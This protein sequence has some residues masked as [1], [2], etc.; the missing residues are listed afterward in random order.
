[1]SLQ[2][3][4]DGVFIVGGGPAGL[5]A[6]IAARLSGLQATVA[7][8]LQPPIDKACGEGLMPDAVAALHALRVR[9]SAR[10]AVPFRGIRF[11]DGRSGLSAEAPFPQGA[12][13][14]VRRTTLHAKLA[15]RAAELGAVLRWGARV[16]LLG[17]GKLL[18]D[19]AEVRCRWLIGAD[20]LQSRV[21]SWSG[22]QPKAFP[23]NANLPIGGRGANSRFG[24]RQHFRAVPW[25]DLVE[26]YWGASCQ[27]AVTPTAPDEVG[28]AMVT[29]NPG[30]RIQGALAE[31]PVLAAHLASAQPATRER[32][33]P[34]VLRRLPALSRGPVALIGDASGSVDPVTGEGLGLA[35]RQ[36]LSLAESLRS[37]DLRS[38]EHAH[39]RIGHVPHR[40]SRL[41]LCM[42]RSPWLRTRALQAMAAEPQLFARLLN[43]QI[44]GPESSPLT[45]LDALRL[46]WHMA[47][48]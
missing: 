3:G 47:K 21:R 19:G 6:A 9:F 46:G 40:M 33:A 2:A 10:Q 26:V 42:D 13:L 8:S 29:R 15:E 32:G 28:L 5:A 39:R 16:A 44:A 18:C 36:A 45:A 4:Q 48:A 23:G 27:I 31:L 1:V 43:A 38:Y 11:L 12:G 22:L 25:T 24:F 7:D 35:F 30:M 20:G 34:C 17:G 41:I 37:G 14:A